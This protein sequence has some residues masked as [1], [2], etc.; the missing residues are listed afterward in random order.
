[1]EFG[2]ETFSI[3]CEKRIIHAEFRWYFYCRFEYPIGLWAEFWHN[4]WSCLSGFSTWIDFN[5]T[6]R[7]SH[8]LYD[9][10]QSRFEDCRREIILM[11]SV[12]SIVPASRCRN[13]SQKQTCR[14]ENKKRYL[15][16]HLG[17]QWAWALTRKWYSMNANWWRSFRRRGKESNSYR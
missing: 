5:R 16:W 10:T 6:S 12:S 4:P 11:F 9:S 14:S 13:Q 3:C 7:S 2:C 1:M 15:V 17:L 8:D